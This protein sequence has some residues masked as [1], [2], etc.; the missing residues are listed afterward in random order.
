MFLDKVKIEKGG[1]NQTTK[2]VKN[3][4]IVYQLLIEQRII[5]W[6][7]ELKWT[8]YAVFFFCLQINSKEYLSEII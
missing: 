4:F 3:I 8:V 1:K 6:K 5:F 2:A 7:N